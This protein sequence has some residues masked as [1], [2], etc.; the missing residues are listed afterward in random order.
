M[1]DRGSF[2]VRRVGKALP[3]FGDEFVS[4]EALSGL[5]LFVGAVA[6]LVWANVSIESYRDVWQHHFDVG[7]DLTV[8]EWV[9]D[10]LMTVFFFVVGLE[11]KREIVRGELRDPR[12]VS[13][14]VLAAIGGMALPA[15][16]YTAL[17]AGGA[18]SE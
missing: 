11:I 12:T 9:N 18:C 15:L 17:N 13:L 2:R 14:P 16:V 7:Y 3:P 5:V 1:A 4:I 8:Q 6:A 10:G